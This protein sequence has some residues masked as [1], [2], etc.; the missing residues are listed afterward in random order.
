M[1]LNE[2]AKL[3]HGDWNGDWL[4]IS[5]PGHKKKDRSLGI[6]FNPKAPD[7]FRVH[8]LAGDDP[9]ECRQHVKELLQKIADGGLLAI[10]CDVSKDE[11]LAMQK[12]IALAL[13]IWEEAIS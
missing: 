11:D 10:E 2:L 7:G 8:S 4:N 9:V 1:K 12:K 6:L 3:L 5:G 13:S